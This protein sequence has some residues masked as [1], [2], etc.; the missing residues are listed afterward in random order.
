MLIEKLTQAVTGTVRFCA[1]EGFSDRFLNDCAA[2]GVVLKNVDVCGNTVTAEVS[3]KS[4]AAVRE[5]CSLSGMKLTRVRARGLRP[6]LLRY[7]ARI[8][9]PIGVFLGAVLYIVLSSMLWSIQITG[10]EET[11]AEA[12]SGY[13]TGIGVSRGVFLFGIDC[14]E[15]ER[16]IEA[17]DPE[18]LRA[19]VN[20]IGCRMYIAVTP[21]VVPPVLPDVNEYCNVVAAKDGEILSADILAGEGFVKDGDPVVKGDLLASGAV[22]L[23]NGGVCFVHAKAVVRARTVTGVVCS[24]PA[25]KDVSRLTQRKDRWSVCFFGVQFPPQRDAKRMCGE[26][27]ATDGSV[28]PIGLKRGRYDEYEKEKIQLNKEQARLLVFTD[29]ACI[30]YRDFRTVPIEEL[31]VTESFDAGARITAAF[32]CVED[33]AKEQIFEVDREE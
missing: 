7:K 5:I 31:R 1:E 8:G 21:R 17:W 13:L 19:A 18:I 9:V 25:E 6:T 12:F 3:C 20:L 28:F 29:L 4:F 33:I 32:V 15:L 30:A 11:K 10:I 24:V 14:N 26:Y 22:P 16:R 27:L 23:K 2:Q